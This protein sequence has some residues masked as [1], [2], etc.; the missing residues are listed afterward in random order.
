MSQA[1]R[2]LRT[3]G[4][5]QREK[6]GRIVRYRL[7]DGQITVAAA[8]TVPPPRL[9]ANGS[10]FATGPKRCATFS[11]QWTFPINEGFSNHT[12]LCTSWSDEPGLRPCET[13]HD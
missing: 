13:V 2:L 7:V 1:P 12:Q 11:V 9:Y 10:L 3:A 5:V 8:I 4:T 6:D